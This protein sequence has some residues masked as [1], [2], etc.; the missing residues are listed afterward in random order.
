MTRKVTGE[1]GI[2]EF[3]WPDKDVAK[4]SLTF[5]NPS[6]MQNHAI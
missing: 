5:L 6:S 4:T 1:E 3:S 2:T